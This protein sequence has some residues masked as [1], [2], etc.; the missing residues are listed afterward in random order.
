VSSH[1]DETVGAH[2]LMTHVDT[3]RLSTSGRSVTASGRRRSSTAAMNTRGRV[4]ITGMQAGRDHSTDAVEA[5][6]Q[7]R[8]IGFVNG[9]ADVPLNGIA[10]PN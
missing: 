6:K 4:R 3:Q 1:S 5:R 7:V 9:G 2:R 8:L 10:A